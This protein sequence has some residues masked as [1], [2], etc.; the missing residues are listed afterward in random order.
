MS[1]H[2]YGREGIR[3]DTAEDTGANGA[4]QTTLILLQK[5]SRKELWVRQKAWLTHCKQGYCI[6]IEAR[7]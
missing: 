1:S 6:R 3:G 7:D 4:G 5:I 2:K